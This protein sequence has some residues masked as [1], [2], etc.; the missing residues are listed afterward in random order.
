MKKFTFG[1]LLFANSFVLLSQPILTATNF[2]PLVGESQLYYIA[3][4]NSLLNNTTGANVVFDYSSL[5]SYGMIQTTRYVDPASTANASDFPTASYADTTDGFPINKRFSQN[6][7]DSLINVGLVLDIN[8]FGTTLGK[9]NSDPETIMKFPFAYGNSFSDNYSGSFTATSAPLPTNGNGI[10][11]VIA[12]AWGTLILPGS[13]N[14]DSVIRVVTIENFVTDTV[15]LPPP[16]PNILPITING[17]LISYY[18]PSLS[19]FA[20][21]SFIT[22]DA[23][24]Q[25]NKTVISQYPM[26]II[27][28][29]NELNNDYLIKIY[30]NPTTGSS[31][32]I[33]LDLQNN[34]F[35][36]IDLVNQLGQKIKSIINK[37]LPKEKSKINLEASL[38]A[39]G[40]YFV[41]IYIDNKL[42]VKKLIIN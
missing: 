14:I 16:L 32:T 8:N 11:S 35:V 42:T 40:I 10:V 12:D 9:Y 29:V 34:A 2:V 3:D 39:K 15:F 38:L 19:K 30:P 23:A 36:K 6:K 37:N 28:S 24:G 17:T 7:T 33:V 27:T 25:T 1:L 31:V 21:L 18:K 4:T 41:N 5:K 13:P 26:P 20:L 22:A